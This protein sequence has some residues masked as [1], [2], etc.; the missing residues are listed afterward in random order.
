MTKEKYNALR[1]RMDPLEL[2]FLDAFCEISKQSR[3]KIARSALKSYLY[4]NI[5]NKKRPNKKVIFSQNMLKPLLD[6]ANEELIKKIA[7]ISFQ[8]GISDHRYLDNILDSLKEGSIPTEYTLDLEGRIKSL[9]E[10]VFNPDAQ[11]WFDSIRYGWNKRI[12]VIGGKHN[13][14]RNFSLFI[15]FLMI[16]YMKIYNYKLKSEEFREYKSKKTDKLSYVIILNFIPIS[17]R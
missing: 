11:N 17:S 1:V 13:L 4:R 9:I 12:L 5:D 16:K 10:N 14:G 2:E 8:N 7:E 3:S 15:K 6:N